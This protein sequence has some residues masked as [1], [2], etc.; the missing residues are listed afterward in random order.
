MRKRVGYGWVVVGLSFAMFFMSS[1]AQ[2]AFPVSLMS[3]SRELGWD[4]SLLGQAMSICMLSTGLSMPIIGK[5]TDKYGPRIVSLL[6]YAV[7]GVSVLLLSFVSEIWQVYLLYGVMLGFTW[8]SIGMVASTTLI[9]KWFAEKRSLPLS[10]FQSAYPI[11]WFCTA[12]L[13]GSLIQVYGWRSTW[14]LLGIILILI[15]AISSFFIREIKTPH[16]EVSDNNM[17][18]G[19]VSMKM[20]V[21]TYF[22]IVIGI[23]IMFMCGFTDTSFAQLWVPIS[24]EWGIDEV[25]ASYWLGYMAAM[26]FIGTIA[27]GPLPRKLGYK[28]PFTLLY[29]IRAASLTLLILIFP[30]MS[31]MA[32]YSFII[33]FGLSFFGMAPILSAWIGETFGEKILG[34]LLG[35]SIFMHFIGAALGIYIFG[36][37]NNIYGTYRPAFLLSL[38]LVLAIIVL[39]CLV[40][41]PSTFKTKSI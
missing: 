5:I 39:C 23:I 1:G 33:L 17:L 14:L 24:V 3:M 4:I 9:S 18:S 21:K 25:T 40:K 20:A 32:Y 37:I 28:I 26:A 11:G 16:I 19:T 10:V 36:L 30:A 2:M 29:V 31:L 7:A 34:G 38:I 15:V 6:G 27:V 35:L 13:A 22:F 8:H 41:S 12:P